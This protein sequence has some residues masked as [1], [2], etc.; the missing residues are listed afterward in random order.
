MALAPTRTPSTAGRDMRS[1]VTNID[2][3]KRIEEV[4]VE[5]CEKRGAKNK[6]KDGNNFKSKNK[7]PRTVRLWMRRKSLAS[8]SSRKLT[9][10]S[11]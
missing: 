7:I 9:V 10:V 4:I 6:N 3:T 2:L 11:V 1:V 5:H 8:K